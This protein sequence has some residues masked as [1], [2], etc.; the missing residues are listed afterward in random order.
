MTFLLLPLS[1]H[2]YLATIVQDLSYQNIEHVYKYPTPNIIQASNEADREN[3][4]M[5][6]IVS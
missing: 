1:T 5:Y 3:N 4:H 2:K 6:Y